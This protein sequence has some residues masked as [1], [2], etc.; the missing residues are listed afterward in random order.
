MVF[1]G[2]ERVGG[3]GAEGGIFPIHYIRTDQCR[4]SRAELISQSQSIC[5]QHAFR[6]QTTGLDI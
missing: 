3:G 5:N 6:S 2:A 4:E 1:L